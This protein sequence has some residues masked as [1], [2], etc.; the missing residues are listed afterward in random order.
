MHFLNRLQN[1]PYQHKKSKLG[2]HR[3]NGWVCFNLNF[4]LSAISQ[5]SVIL[6]DLSYSGFPLSWTNNRFWNQCSFSSYGGSKIRILLDVQLSLHF[7]D[8]SLDQLPAISETPSK[9]RS[10]EFRERGRRNCGRAQATLPFSVN[11]TKPNEKFH[12]KMVGRGFPPKMQGKRR[13]TSSWSSRQNFWPAYHVFLDLKKCSRMACVSRNPISFKTFTCS[14]WS[15]R[16]HLVTFSDIFSWCVQWKNTKEPPT[17]G[18]VH[19]WNI[20]RKFALHV[21]TGGEF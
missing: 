4:P 21:T 9:S 7:P 15:V 2:P 14:T 3:R 12:S 10:R 11:S 20:T 13:A 5:L 19:K 18:R 6:G 8:N 17:T 1:I 16:V